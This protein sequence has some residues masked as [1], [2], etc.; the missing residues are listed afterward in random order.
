MGSTGRST[1]S[2]LHYEVRIDGRAVNPIPF[3]KSNDYLLAM[4]KKGAGTHSMDAVALGGPNAPSAKLAAG[5][6]R[7]YLADVT[8]SFPYPQRRQARRLHCRQAGQARGAA[9]VGRRRR[10]RR[11][12]L[13]VRAGRAGGGRRGGRAP[14]ASAWW[15]I[16]S[17]SSC[18]RASEVDYVEDLG[19]ASFKVTNPNA[20]SGCGCGSSFSV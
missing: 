5:P 18:S 6:P 12:L 19:G 15:S 2:H 9:P 11:L 14:T 17:A 7:P 1:G 4:Q 3:M 8:A 13:P 10:L 20:A 16:R